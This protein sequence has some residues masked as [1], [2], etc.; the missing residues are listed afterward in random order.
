MFEDKGSGI[1]FLKTTRA[2]H[3]EEAI[4]HTEGLVTVLRLSMA[5]IKPA[6]DALTIAKGFFDAHQYL[7]AVQ[8]A[9]RAETIAIALDE[10]FSGYQKALQDLHAQ[11]ESMKRLGLDTEGLEKVAGVA[12][13]KVVAGIWETGAFVPNY[14]EG[15]ALLEKATNEGRAFQEKAQIASNQIF[16]AELAIE[17]VGNLR[18]GG[19]PGSEA[20][21]HGAVS[22]LEAALHDATKELALGNADGAATI[23]KELEDK[24]RSLRTQFGTATTGL[25]EIEGKLADLRSEG[26]LTVSVELQ[27]KMA[28]DLLDRGLI[29]PAAAM[30]ARLHGETKSLGDRYRKATT[31]L[32]DAEILYGRL[33]REGFHSYEADAA[34]R[35]ARRCLREGA[36]GRSIQHLER[37]LQAFARRTNARASLAKAI[38]ETRTRVKLLAGSGLS[39]MPD[40]QEVLGRAEREF[41]QGNYAGSSEDLRIATVLLDGV[42]RAPEKK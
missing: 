35:D 29:E 10:R 24:A 39:F 34:L 30:A 8:A 9:K 7:K 18:G 15:R 23:A 21:S 16:V 41:Q 40:I 36:Y 33:Q 38:E 37:A 31:T 3:A 42:T 22:G 4:G 1:G 27:V 20:F 11:I 6:E 25:K 13:E 28:R 32:S 19:E 14:L 2:R 12:E 5:D 26:V 17:S